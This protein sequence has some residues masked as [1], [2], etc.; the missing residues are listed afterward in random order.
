M[1]SG[2]QELSEMIQR[3]LEGIMFAE[4]TAADA[5]AQAQT[6]AEAILSAANPAE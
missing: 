6:E 4:L 3:K 2:G 1:I 5:A